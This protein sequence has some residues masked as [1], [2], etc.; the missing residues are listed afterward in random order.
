[1]LKIIFSMRSDFS[2]NRIKKTIESD[3]T[4]ESVSVYENNIEEINDVKDVVEINNPN[5]YIIDKSR[6]DWEELFRYSNKVGQDYIFF[7]G[8][9]EELKEDIASYFSLEIKEET[10]DRKQINYLEQEEQKEKIVYRDRIV[11]KEVI[12]T[13]YTSIPN[14]QVAIVNLWQGAGATTVT[15]NLAR[16]ISER[17]LNVGVIES[18]ISNPYLFDYLHIERHE[19]INRNFYYVDL[20]QQIYANA[21]FKYRST[22]FHNNGIDWYVNDSRLYPVQHYEVDDYLR[23]LLSINSTIQLIDL[24]HSIYDENVQ[25]LLKHMDHVFV[26]LEP[27]PVK[28]DWLSELRDDG[29]PLQEQRKERHMLQF[30]EGLSSSGVYYDFILNKYS[31]KGDM[32]SF[33]SSLP[34]KPISQI[35]TFSYQELNKCVWD[36]AFIYDQHEES[37]EKAYLPIL[38]KFLPKDYIKKP[39][40]E[41]T[42]LLEGFKKI[43]DLTRR[44]KEENEERF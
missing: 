2:F 10:T 22:P 21:S 28:L 3:A 34:K 24:S 36:S 39:N 43:K 8:D 12:K 6:K 32:K 26:V 30:L 18:P 35:P 7:E 23:V 20:A 16:A 44:E 38:S 11:E 33:V 31:Q 19:Q 1:M 17:G 41:K 15:I 13:E 4:F 29:V 40:K 14:T 42:S 27:D 37:L 5:L 25:E 9:Y